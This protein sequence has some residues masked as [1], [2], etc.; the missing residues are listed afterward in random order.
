MRSRHDDKSARAWADICQR[1]HRA[2][3]PV[4]H[5][6]LVPLIRVLALVS[7]GAAVEVLSAAPLVVHRDAIRVV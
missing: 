7:A 6:S 1:V 2:D 3:Q 4:V 5:P